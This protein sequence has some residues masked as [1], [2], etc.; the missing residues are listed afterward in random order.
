[1][2]SATGSVCRGNDCKERTITQGIGM[3]AIPT[4]NFRNAAIEAL[5][6]SD[7][8]LKVVATGMTHTPRFQK[9]PSPWFVQQKEKRVS[10]HSALTTPFF[11]A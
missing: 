1:M 2:P 9:Q 8:S 7:G 5:L 11:R 6:S 4:R 3:L 10:S